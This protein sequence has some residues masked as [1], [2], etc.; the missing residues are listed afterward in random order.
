MN[1]EESPSFMKDGKAV[2]VMGDCQVMH[3]DRRLAV[4]MT[5]LLDCTLG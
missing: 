5:Q 1:T 3:K 4:Y 2:D